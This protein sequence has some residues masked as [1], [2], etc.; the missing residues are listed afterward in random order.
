MEEQFL[1]VC[2]GKTPREGFPFPS[3]FLVLPLDLRRD[4]VTFCGYCR[5]HVPRSLADN[6][7]SCLDWTCHDKAAVGEWLID[8]QGGQSHDGSV[9]AVQRPV[10]GVRSLDRQI[11]RSSAVIEGGKEKICSIWKQIASNALAHNSKTTM[12]ACE[13]G[14]SS[15]VIRRME[16]ET[17]RRLP[18]STCID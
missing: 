15:E 8:K 4:L 18:L 13:R 10:A 11:I 9:R 6:D 12:F 2:V 1:S 3:P 5:G 16:G 7:L 17:E 14:G